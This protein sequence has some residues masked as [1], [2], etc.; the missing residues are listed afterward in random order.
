MGI[1]IQNLTKKFN[2]VYG[3]KNLNANIKEGELV[4]ILGPSGCGK[5]TTLFLIA[6]LHTPTS[7]N[8]YFGDKLINDVPIEKRGIGMVFQ[9]YAL[10]PH[11]TVEKNIGF[12]LKMQKLNKNDIKH[13]VEEMSKFLH[14]TELLK[15]KPSQLSGGQQQR[16]AIA[17]ALIK[18]PRIL[19][20]DEPFSNLDA[21]LRIQLKHEIKRIQQELNITT[22]FVTHD[23]EEAMSISDRILLM[24]DGVLQQ[25]DTPSDMYLKPKNEFVA[26]FLGNP[27]INLLEVDEIIDKDKIKV[28]GFSKVIN[29][30][31]CC[32]E[33]ELNNTVTKIGIRP[34]DISI[35]KS[36]DFDFEGEIINYQMLGKEVHL[37]IKI[38]DITITTVTPWTSENIKG[39]VKLKIN[40]IHVF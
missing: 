35:V 5:S 34:E 29:I 17:R 39:K 16:V 37:I 30:R 2:Q 6:G 14:I 18:K 28:K 38:E 32:E 8:I 26:R 11:M 33:S 36:D 27:E 22:L 25:F 15:R 10:Y 40:K 1:T 31:N 19:L 3:V 20:L 7:G 21:R 13:R 24:K 12:P 9:N 4:S 23:Q